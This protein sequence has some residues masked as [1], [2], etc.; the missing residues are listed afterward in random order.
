M[1][2][3]DALN[4]A[5]TNPLYDA[6]ERRKVLQAL[7]GKLELSK[8]MASYLSLLFDKGRIGYLSDIDN[9]YQKLADELKGIARANLVSATELSSDAVE[10]IRASLSQRTGREI[11]L[12][13]EQ[14]P[15]LIGGIV[16]KI[17]DLVLDGSI[18]TQLLNMRESLRR[19]EGS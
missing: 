8:V 19:G 17:G 15:G 18:K 7:I 6:G 5:I 12:E 10:K 3:E 2:R 1:A 9:F 4:E 13:V 16:T 11:I 14:D